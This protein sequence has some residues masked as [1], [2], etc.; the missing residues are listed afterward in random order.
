MKIIAFIV[1]LMFIYQKIKK[2]WYCRT[3]EKALEHQEY[4]FDEIER[5]YK[6]LRKEGKWYIGYYGGILLVAISWGILAYLAIL[7]YCTL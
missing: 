1:I 5:T 7:G 6:G 4:I 3:P 2:V